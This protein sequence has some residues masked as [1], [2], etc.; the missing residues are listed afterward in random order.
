MVLA[1]AL[2]KCHPKKHNSEII[3][4]FSTS[5]DALFSFDKICME[6]KIAKRWTSTAEVMIAI[7][8]LLKQ[9]QIFKLK[10]EMYNMQVS[11]EDIES[12]SSYPI[13]LV[14]SNRLGIKTI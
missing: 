3:K 1:Q 11:I 7:Q 14:V 4:E 6:G 9:Q 10:I 8:D 12:E 13:L 5:N 2:K